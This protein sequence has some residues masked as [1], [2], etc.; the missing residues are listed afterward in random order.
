MVKYEKL[1]VFLALFAV[2]VEFNFMR[3]HG[4]SVRFIFLLSICRM[5]VDCGHMQ[6]AMF[7]RD[8]LMAFQADGIMNMAGVF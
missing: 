1:A 8:P 7:Q 5:K 2:A 3:N 4:E 6:G